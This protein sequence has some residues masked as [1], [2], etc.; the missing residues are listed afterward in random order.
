MLRCARLLLCH[1][2]HNVAFKTLANNN[3]RNSNSN[4]KS[5]SYNGSASPNGIIPIRFGAW[6]Q[7][8]GGKLR[9]RGS[10]LA[11]QTVPLAHPT[12]IKKV[13]E[14]INIVIKK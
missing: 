13:D 4:N 6:L 7:V 5:D 11:S 3:S 14:I 2:Y 8:A 1:S 10:F 9:V 12:S